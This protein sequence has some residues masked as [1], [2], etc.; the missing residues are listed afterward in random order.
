MT[1]T[2]LTVGHTRQG[3]GLSAIL[4]SL[5]REEWEGGKE[6]GEGRELTMDIRGEKGGER[7]WGHFM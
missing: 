6:G 5:G 3:C 4:S 7:E 1:Y 2:G